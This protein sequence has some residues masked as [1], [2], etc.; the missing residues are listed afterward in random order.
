MAKKENLRDRQPAGFTLI[1]LLVVIAIIAVLLAITIPAVSKAMAAGQRA[2]CASNLRQIGAAVHLYL[3]DRNGLFPKLTYDTQ[4]R[5][6]SLFNPYLADP[7]IYI[8]PSAKAHGSSGSVWPADYCSTA[9]NVNFCTDYKLNDSPNIAG[10]NIARL[11][12]PARFVIVRDIDWL[13]TE[14]H[15]G[16]D[17]LAFF[18][19]H[20]EALSH[21][22]SQKSD[23]RGN[24]P[25]YNW[26]TL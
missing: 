25:W 2:A 4:Y 10:L 8:C 20:V 14:R 9:S 23:P 3:S 24:A 13:P 19:G 16:R 11:M 7:K 6:Y 15:G 26:G 22:D 17:N 5:Q 18:D 21:V 12:L 1:E